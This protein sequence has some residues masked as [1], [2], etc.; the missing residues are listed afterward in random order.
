M[1]SHSS[2]V[3]IRHLKRQKRVIAQDYPFFVIS[4]WHCACGCNTYSVTLHKT[5]IGYNKQ[6]FDIEFETPLE[7][8]MKFESLVRECEDGKYDVVR[9]LKEGEAF[10]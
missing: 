3:P 10:E 4:L 9:T 8:F 2:G 6:L 1:I 5:D 7:A